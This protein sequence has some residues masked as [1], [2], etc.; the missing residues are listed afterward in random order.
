MSNLVPF[1]ENGSLSN[2]SWDKP[3][4]KLGKGVAILGLGALGFGLYKILPFLAAMAWNAVS[5]SV[6]VFI[7]ILLVSLLTS[8]KFWNTLST[9]YLI[10]MH[11]ILYALVS[12]DPIAIL[13]DYIHQLEVQIQ[14]VDAAMAKFRGLISLN[15]TRL[16][17]TQDLLKK[18]LAEK[19]VL[20]KK[21]ETAMATQVNELIIMYEET[22]R[23]RQERLATSEKWM[24]ALERV[25]EYAKFS[26]GT[27]KEKI[28]LLKEM[29][30]E[31]KQAAKAARSLKKAVHGDPEKL[32]NFETALEVME[33]KM[34]ANIG[35]VEDM[36]EATTGL[37]READ[38]E[39]AVSNE[40]ANAILAQYD[41]NE[42]VFS[43]D[44]WKALPAS[45][46]EARVLI[47][48]PAGQQNGQKQQKGRYFNN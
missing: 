20:E 41:R 6:A 12:S 17:E 27:N 39:S 11:K 44:N 25:R 38:L 10:L 30:E 37:L 18:K 26:V 40:R 48:M 1:S 46:E 14:N 28:K 33:Q 19:A 2:L 29:Y 13:N 35:E 16:K 4:G 15:K 22:L 5:F 34:S 45:E 43:Q 7:L 36:L 47:T 31:A 42:G 21:G 9:A 24:Q 32:T 23:N 8:K 3:E